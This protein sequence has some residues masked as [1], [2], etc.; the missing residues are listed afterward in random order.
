MPKRLH[1]SIRGRV[2]GVCYRAYTRDKARGLDATGWVRNR[3]DGSV[4]LV[5]EGEAESLQGLLDWCW[6]GS[7]W[8]QVDGIDD[9]WEEATGEFTD[10]VVAPTH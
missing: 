8:A 4:E 7:P 10:F 6:Q 3:L 2:Q 9:R 1:L 5:A